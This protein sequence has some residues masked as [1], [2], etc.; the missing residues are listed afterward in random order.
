[1]DEIL[2]LA[3]TLNQISTTSYFTTL[4]TTPIDGFLNS[5]ECFISAVD[6][7]SRVL[8]TL[9]LYLPSDK[10]RAVIIENLNDEHGNGD[11]TKS[12]VNTFSALLTSLGYQKTI[13]VYNENLPSYSAVKKFNDNLLNEIQ[14]GDWIYSVALLGMIEY[15]YIEASKHIHNYLLIYLQELQIN[16]Y[17]THEVVDVRHATELFRLLEPVKDS[18]GLLIIKGMYTGYTLLKNLYNDLAVFL[19]HTTSQ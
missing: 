2:E 3:N 17:S 14:K 8:G 15:T 10:E 19:P 16:H 5:Q 9:L 12:H 13:K 1:M 11:I 7:W 18:H 4:P 6:N